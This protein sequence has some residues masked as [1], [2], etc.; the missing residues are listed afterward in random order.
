[1]EYEGKEQKP[2]KGVLGSS[3][4][5]IAIP[6][7]LFLLVF[8]VVKKYGNLPIDI[9]TH[10]SMMIG[11]GCG[12]LFQLS[13]ALCGLFR[14]TFKVVINRVKT[15]FSNLTINVKFAFK[16]Y[17]EDIVTE[18]IV[19]WIYFII[20]GSTFGCFLFGAIKSYIYYITYR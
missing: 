3:L 17:W 20:I 13:C 19:F 6:T 8:L 7:F 10:F 16:Y 5:L 2:Y 18:G 15:F 11:I 12:L 4:L 9:T 14:G 1:M